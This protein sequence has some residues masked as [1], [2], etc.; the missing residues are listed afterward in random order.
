MKRRRL[1]LFS[2]ELSQKDFESVLKIIRDELSE[3]A[4]GILS[5]SNLN[6][7]RIPKGTLKGANIYYLNCDHNTIGNIEAGAFEGAT[8]SV[9]S[10]GGRGANIEE[11]FLDV[12]TVGCLFFHGTM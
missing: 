1:N 11:G 8:F 10:V 3:Y 9:L 12:A 7:E 6:V 2:L 4:I 5:F